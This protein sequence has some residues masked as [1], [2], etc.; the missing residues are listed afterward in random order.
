MRFITLAASLLLVPISAGQEQAE[1]KVEVL[2][3]L[4][5]GE[6]GYYEISKPEFVYRDR[7]QS[8]AGADVK[9]FV[10][11]SFGGKRH[12]ICGKL[13]AGYW[14][15]HEDL[16]LNSLRLINSY[17]LPSSDPKLEFLLVIFEYN[18][19][20]G[21]SDS[22]G[23]VQVWKLSG[24]HLLIQQQIEYNTHFGGAGAYQKFSP[25]DQHLAVRASHYLPGDAHCCI[26][27]YDELTFH[28]TGSEY[29]LARIETK[30]LNRSSGT[31][32]SSEKVN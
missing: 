18:G 12:L 10:I 17:P 23:I 20:S 6:K 31:R 26:S 1:P 24:S 3:P 9:N 13:K 5:Y 28:W 19:V 11:H 4:P 7:Y 27:A 21:S 29:R 2:S 25:E 32:S 14:E 15:S 16:A 22:S 30:R 8:F